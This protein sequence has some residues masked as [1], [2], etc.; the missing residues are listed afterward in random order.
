MAGILTIA[1]SAAPIRGEASGTSQTINGQ[2]ISGQ[3]PSGEPGFRRLSEAEYVRSIGQIFG[4]SV[5]V[6]GRFDPPRRV[7]GLLAIG[8]G[9]VTV[10]S[11]GIEQY[12]LRAREI[13][14]QAVAQDRRAATISCA[15][16]SAGFDRACAASYLS[17]YGRLLYR[18]PLTD[19][20]MTVVLA[21]AQDVT[22]RSGNFDRGL[23]TGLSR[24]L[25]SPNFIFRVEGS[26]VDPA[27]PAE[28]R[29]DPY[30]LATRISFLLW[31]APPDAALLD[32]AAAGDLN[33]P[34][35]LALQV[36]RL[37]ADPRFEQGVRS[38]FSDMLGYD[39]FQGLAKDQEIYPKFTSQMASDAQEQSLRTIVDLL[40]TQKGDY[41][42][43]FTTKK[44]FM[45]R[46]LG[47]LY[48]VPV[49]A[50]AMNGWSPYVFGP[51]DSRGGL[52]S[53]AA[54]LMLDPTHEGRSSPTIRGKT[55]REFLLCQPIPQPPPNVDFAVVQDVHNPEFRTARQRLAVHAENPACAG[56]HALTDPIGLSMENYDATGG[57]RSHENNA[58][59]DATGTFD[60]KPYTGVQGISRLLHDSPDA[61]MCLVQRSFEYGVG[62]PAADGDADW[63]DTANQQF[64]K[65]GYRFPALLRVIATSKAFAK[66][67]APRPVGKPDAKVALK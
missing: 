2:T 38:F 51:N 41:R 28:R 39:M 45:N 14:K 31:D 62:R 17:K 18:R 3:T 29:L 54:F 25:I 53:L 64:A 57:F 67:A 65:A 59:I 33:D 35:K 5:H 56:C 47:A 50:T 7:D 49:D 19:R 42:D 8:E 48:R 60:G 24:L 52:L 9:S 1:W 36:D 22:A 15:S 27:N 58:L 55:V 40:L 63:V 34:A 66:V 10:S 13:A 61:P 23:E 21:L 43:L 11:S 30:S 46:N 37:M 20:E 26:E 32:A 6:P 44:T 4:A 16:A 12:E